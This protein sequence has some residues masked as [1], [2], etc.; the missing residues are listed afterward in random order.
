MACYRP[1][2]RRLHF[3]RV[4]SVYLQTSHET[5]IKP[6]FEEN[7]NELD[8]SAKFRLEGA[9]DAEKFR[10]RSSKASRANN[11]PKK[12]ATPG[13]TRLRRNKHWSW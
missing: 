4:G 1:L 6:M 9:Q 10:T 8:Y 12:P 3:I 2:A 11:R 13:S 7:E 5:G